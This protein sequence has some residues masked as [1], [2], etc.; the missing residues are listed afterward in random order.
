MFASKVTNV[1]I[2]VMGYG[3]LKSDYHTLICIREALSSIRV[4]RVA[5][6]IEILPHFLNLMFLDSCIIV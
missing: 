5:I 4:S 6:V 3:L 2:F 1:R